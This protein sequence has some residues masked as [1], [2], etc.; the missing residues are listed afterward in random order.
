MMTA[1]EVTE[2]AIRLC[3][4]LRVE[5]IPEDFHRAG[6]YRQVMAR[7]VAEYTN[8]GSLRE[9]LPNCPPKC[10]IAARAG[11]QP[12]TACFNYH[13]ARDILQT[14]ARWRALVM[15]AACEPWPVGAV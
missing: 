8:Y 13:L 9:A 12:G 7:V 4:H 5:L 1:C 6:E 14:E 3:L 10:A 11:L 15:F 2:T